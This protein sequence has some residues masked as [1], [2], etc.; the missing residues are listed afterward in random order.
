MNLNLDAHATPA[1][2]Q[3]ADRLQAE[4][5]IAN[6]VKIHDLIVSC[7]VADG[8]DGRPEEVHERRMSD[9]SCRCGYNKPKIK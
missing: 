8:E 4:D 2:R 1:E 6:G 7:Y 9:R 3:E 5:V